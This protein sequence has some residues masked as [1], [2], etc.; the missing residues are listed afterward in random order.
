MNRLKATALAVTLTLAGVFAAAPALATGAD[1]TG[2]AAVRVG[3]GAPPKVTAANTGPARTAAGLKGRPPGASGGVRLLSGPWYNYGVGTQ[4]PAVAPTTVQAN[5]RIVNA[6]VD[7]ADNCGHTLMEIAVTKTE[8]SG[9]RH[10]AEAGFRK[11]CADSAPKMFVF[12]W[13]NEVPQ[14]YGT[15]FVNYTGAGSSAFHPG[16]S[17]AAEVGLTR[18]FG[19]K[20]D[21]ATG[22][23]W[24]YYGPSSAPLWVG[25][26]PQTVWSGGGF[27]FT[28]AAKVQVFAEVGSV[29]DAFPCTDMGDG[30]FGTAT[31][32]GFWSSVS[33]NAGA[34]APSMTWGTVP[35]SGVSAAFTMFPLSALSARMGGPMW[36]FAGT[37]GGTTGGC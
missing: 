13:V 17:L 14:G 21:P 2:S 10:I 27:S 25:Y 6:Y 12:S 36:D 33:Y 34:T 37:A 29:V 11:T 4:T 35:S 16:D 1:P 24:L 15:G 8:P 23:W 32:G 30:N 3:P 28:A 7:P 9:N 5:T 26:F 18:T 20:Y 19:W 22:A 31:T